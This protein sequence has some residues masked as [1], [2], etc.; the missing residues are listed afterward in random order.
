AEVELPDGTAVTGFGLHPA[1]F[2][3]A[4]HAIALGDFV[5]ATATGPM[6]PFVW[7]GV[8]LHAT[9]ASTVRVRLARA[10]TDAVSLAITDTAGAPVLSVESLALRPLESTRLSTVQDSMF[11][12]EW[13]EVAA[14]AWDGDWTTI[15]GDFAGPVPAA[16]VV[17]SLVDSAVGVVRSARE[18]VAAAL[19]LVQ[20]W[21]GEDRFGESLLV[22]LTAGS[23]PADAAVQGLVRSAQMENP[24]RFVLLDLGAAPVTSELLGVALGSGEPELVL[25]DGRWE[26][27]RLVRVVASSAAVPVDGTV[28]ITGG[29]GALGALLA[30]HLVVEHGLRS[31]VLTSRRGLDAPG[32][33][34]LVAE[35]SALGAVVRVAA[36]DVSDREAVA[37]LLGGI[38]DLRGVVHTAGV[39]DDGLVTS[40]SSERLGVVFGPKVD[41]AYYLHELTVS[42]DLDMFVV[43]SSASGV[44]GSGGQGNYAAANSFLDE[45]IRQRNA[46]GLVGTSLAWGLWEQADGMGAGVDGVAGLSEAEGLALFDVGWAQGG[47][48]VP[49]RLDLPALRKS[50]DVPPILRSLVRKSRRTAQRSGSASGWTEQIAALAAGE[51]LEAVLNLVRTAAAGVLGH[52]GSEAVGPTA[53]FKELGFDS[54]TAIELRNQLAAK[55]GLRLPATLVFDYPT[56]TVAAEFILGLVVGAATPVATGIVQPRAEDPIVVV[57]MACRY[58]GGA[59]SPEQLWE[60]VASGGDGIGAFPD[61]RGWDV[62]DLLDT[63][64]YEVAGGF[65]YDAAGFDPGFFGISP[66]EALAMDPQQRLLL[67]SSWEAFESAGINPVSV[68]GSQTGVFAGVMYHNYGARVIDVPD[69]VEAFLGTGSS[70]SVVSGRVSYMFG[71]EG[72]AVTVDTACSSSL[73]TLHLAAQSLGRGECDLALAGGVTVMP[74]PD[75][76]ASFAQQ[77]G[78]ARNGRCKAFAGAADG[79]GWSEGVGMLV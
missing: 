56:A 74:T 33:E 37:G 42:R 62:A 47:V 79:T 17:P 71:F 52:D 15:D 32:A 41:A 12:L 68:R 21:V 22:F 20:R 11:G 69:G 50:G 16:V 63:S 2:D 64:V 70:S 26:A 77:Q 27:P 46:A 23:G 39:L 19:A 51:R 44:L 24:G 76:F 38:A 53:A 43:F 66:R 31:L 60:L 4:L 29:T 78:L 65:L 61:D 54:L 30:R 28:L 10:G 6:L 5:E 58:P 57:G 18:A 72:P 40:L 13:V 8:G 34:G 49:M 36:C 55:T 48:L 45:L 67:E 1:L 14:H 73:V 3:A 75:T 25:R 7:S 35:L 9:G 59:A